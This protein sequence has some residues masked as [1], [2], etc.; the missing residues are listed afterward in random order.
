[1]LP[2]LKAYIDILISKKYT[3]LISF[4]VE[5]KVSKV[6]YGGKCGRA[7]EWFPIYDAN[8]DIYILDPLF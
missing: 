2:Y 5:I 3:K 4:A 1:M 7:N 6:F 8:T